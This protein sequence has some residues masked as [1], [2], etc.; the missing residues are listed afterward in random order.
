MS[1]DNVLFHLIF[2]ITGLSYLSTLLTG[3]LHTA[4]CL[5]HSPWCFPTYFSKALLLLFI[6]Q[7]P[8][9]HHQ[10]LWTVLGE[11]KY[12]MVFSL[13]E[14]AVMFG[15]ETF[16]YH[17]NIVRLVKQYEHVRSVTATGGGNWGC[18]TWEE[19]GTTSDRRGWCGL[20]V[21]RD[22]PASPGSRHW[23]N[24]NTRQR[25]HYLQGHGDMKYS[26]FEDI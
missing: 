15:R 9:K 8:L 12:D 26:K 16:D 17:F 4:S 5:I 6:H 19:W 21:W 22:R 14:I 23:G 20:C 11:G 18:I 13:V 24:A 7:V 10:V 2:I 25:E 3:P 1:I